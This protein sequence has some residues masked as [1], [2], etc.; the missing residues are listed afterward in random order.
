MYSTVFTLQQWS[1]AAILFVAEPI[2]YQLEDLSTVNTPAW[3]LIIHSTQ[4]YSSIDL[5]TL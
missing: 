3:R 4:L 5:C 2:C 1:A